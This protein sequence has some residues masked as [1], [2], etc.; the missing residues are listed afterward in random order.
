VSCVFVST[1]TTK[2]LQRHHRVAAYR[3][4]SSRSAD[5]W[6]VAIVGSGPSGCYTA[7]YL[8]S[9]LENSKIDVLERLATPYG[10]VRNGVAPDHPEV[11]NVERDFDKLF[12]DNNNNNN[13]CSNI[14]F[15]GNVSVGKD[16]SLE[17]LRQLY[18]IVVLAYGCETDRPFHFLSN[19]HLEGILSAREFVAWYNGH[20]DYE[21]V[22]PLVQQAFQRGDGNSQNAVVIGHGNVALDCARILS[23]TRQELDETDIATRALDVLKHDDSSDQTRKISVVGRRGHIQGAF[24]IKELRE[25]TKLPHAD[26]VVQTEELDMGRT[27]ASQQELKDTRPRK[28]MDKLLTAAAMSSSEKRT[29]KNT[30]VDLRFLL[31]PVGFESE[32]GSSLSNVIC[33]RTRLT[34]EVGC[35]IAEGTGEIHNIKAQL[36]CMDHGFSACRQNETVC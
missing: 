6:K 12:E 27:P 10:L 11:K 35:Q 19:S 21:W 22:G 32:D 15:Y 30:Q 8:N 17:D 23:K 1:R 18:D 28:R 25:L 2:L 4:F 13:N 7:K 20:V 14:Q 16:V 3:F 31:N 36:V 24:T 29:N 5:G 9:V 33:E 26:F 34:G